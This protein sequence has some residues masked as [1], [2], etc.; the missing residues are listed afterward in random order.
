MFAACSDPETGIVPDDVPITVDVQPDT[1]AQD[2]GIDIVD[3]TAE[4]IADVEVVAPDATTDAQEDATKDTAEDTGQDTGGPDVSECDEKPAPAFC[5][6]K[7]DDDCASEYCFATSQGKECAQLCESECPE[8]YGCRPVGGGGD[9]VYLCVE[10][11]INLCKPCMS[12]ADCVAPGYAGEDTCVS[13]GDSGSFCGI[14]CSVDS[15]CPAGYGCED[16]Q[17]VKSDGV[18]SCAP[19]HIS[20]AA[21]TACVNATAAG[22]C[23]G[24]RMCS[25]DGL[26]E[27]L[28]DDAVEEICD[29][30]DNDCNGVVDDLKNPECTLENAFGSCPG[31]LT[32][33]GGGAVCQGE[34]PAPESCDGIDNDCD[35]V[36]D[37]GFANTDEDLM[38]DCVDP[39][40]DNDGFDD[41]NDNCPKIPNDQ[42]DTD[43]DGLGNDCD[44]DDDND[45]TPDALDCEPLLASAY[46]LAPEVCDGI[47]NDCDELIDE[48]TCKDGDLCTDDICSPTDGCLHPFNNE[49]C[50]DGNPCTANDACVLGFCQGDFSVCDD[51]SPCTVDQ[52][53]PQTG[54]THTILQGPC[55]DGNACTSGDI[56]GAGGQCFGQPIF[57]DDDEE[58]TD[59][60]CDPEVGCTFLPNAD[61]CDDGSACTENDHCQN[62]ACA[63]DFVDCN[64]G[65]GCTD[66]FCDPLFGCTQQPNVV[67]CEDGDPCTTQDLCADGACNGIPVDCSAFDA[68]CQLGVCQG[69]GCVA[70]EIACNITEVVIDTPGGVFSG[71][72]ASGVVVRGSIGHGGPVGEAAAPGKHS[73]T[74]GFQALSNP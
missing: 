56:C 63:G 8:G 44:P 5:A 29:G 57:C 11:A 73:I 71:A 49:S 51:G 18:C 46:P 19:L 53:T 45:G 41:E 24:T 67:P 30:V 62:G 28:G 69:G 64:D 36:I 72:G 55:D 3:V 58:C 1:T 10:R 59:D 43:L 21:K 16:G 34:P 27:C 60:S 17:C 42:L 61:D 2:T 65:N 4:V 32:C 22:S 70:E 6:C 40:D 23:E 9:P 47:D 35:D 26:T 33:I 74:F 25:E 7:E 48:A 39:D 68:P 38:A 20:V 66:D 13:Y 52:C 50:N 14:G 12:N 54:C 37:E 31:T 15:P